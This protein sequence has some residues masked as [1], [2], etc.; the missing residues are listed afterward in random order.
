MVASTAI[1]TTYTTTVVN[2]NVQLQAQL[3]KSRP[4]I[5]L[6][7]YNPQ[8]QSNAQET[9]VEWAEGKRKQKQKSWETSLEM[10]IKIFIHVTG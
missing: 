4:F 6:P 7:K 3:V 1:T 2:I 5:A 9:S 10:K 8:S